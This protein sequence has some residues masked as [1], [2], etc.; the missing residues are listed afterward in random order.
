MAN[1]QLE[2]LKEL[3]NKSVI[4][5]TVN[6]SD[7]INNFIN[8]DSIIEDDL[9]FIEEETS[10]APDDNAPDDN[11]I[12]DNDDAKS[13]ISRK[14]YIDNDKFKKAFRDMDENSEIV[15]QCE[16]EKY[17]MVYEIDEFQDQLISTG[18][19]NDKKYNINIDTPLAQLKEIHTLLK[20]KYYKSRYIM[21]GTKMIEGVAYV[22]EMVFNGERTLGSLEFNLTG[23]HREVHR[24][25]LSVRSDIGSCFE[26]TIVSSMSPLSRILLELTVSG[27]IYGTTNAKKKKI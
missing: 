20:I 19:F 1:I 9:P 14:S 7:R 24:K 21:M 2:G 5:S 17:M 26:N 27:L 13:D 18:I 15:D 3:T 22:M 23:W 4:Q 16:E 6:L 12:D 11:E 8:D 25:V 10:N